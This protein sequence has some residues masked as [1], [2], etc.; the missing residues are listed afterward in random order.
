MPRL[1]IR[2]WKLGRAA[3]AEMNTL[4]DTIV[5][6]LAAVPILCIYRRILGNVLLSHQK[7]AHEHG[8]GSVMDAALKLVPKILA[9]NDLTRLLIAVWEKK[10]RS[11]RM[12]ERNLYGKLKPAFTMIVY[13]LWPLIYISNVPE[14]YPGANE[15][16]FV[17]EGF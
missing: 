12:G 5:Q 9:S 14:Y 6:F 11:M 4:P 7:H 1:N 17:S 2:V 10:R 16:H 13:S 15:S 8:F 3:M